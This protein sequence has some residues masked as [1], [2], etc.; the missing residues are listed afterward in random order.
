MSEDRPSVRVR[1]ASDEETQADTEALA[2]LEASW[3]SWSACHLPHPDDS[4]GVVERVRAT[5][6]RWWRRWFG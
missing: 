5:V 6:R 2:R 3:E 4:P 1:I